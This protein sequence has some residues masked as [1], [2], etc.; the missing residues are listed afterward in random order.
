[1][2]NIRKSDIVTSLVLLLVL[3]V[4]FIPIPTPLLDLLLVIMWRSES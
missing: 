3:A 1:M 4:M 2:L